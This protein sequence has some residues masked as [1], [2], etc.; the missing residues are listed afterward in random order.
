MNRNKMRENLMV[1]VYQADIHNNYEFEFFA[2]VY[3]R[4]ENTTDENTVFFK[5]VI[6]AFIDFKTVV[7]QTISENLK[8]WELGRIGKVELAILRIST[9]EML[10]I[11]N[12]PLKVSVNE[13][14]ELAKK[15]ADDNAPNYINGV[16]ASIMSK[17]EN[18]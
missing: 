9:T 3:E 18:D 15:F 14:V 7:D 17:I 16:L 8:K 4:I 11:K 13:A 6:G 1:M 12:I 10:Y 2:K 5:E